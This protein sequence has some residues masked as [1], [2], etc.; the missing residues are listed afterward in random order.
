MNPQYRSKRVTLHKTATNQI[1]NYLLTDPF[2]S[3]VKKCID[4][5]THMTFSFDFEAWT[6]C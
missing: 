6:A 5:W 3:N 4:A 2:N 1:Q